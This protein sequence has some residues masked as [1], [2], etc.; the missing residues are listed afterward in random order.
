VKV[1]LLTFDGCPNA[2]AARELVARV[3]AQFAPDAEVGEIVIPDGEAAQ[4]HRFLGSPTIRVDGRDIE[5]G[6]DE[7]TDYV[8][9]CRLYRTSSGAS[10]MP[11]EAWLR[12]AL[13]AA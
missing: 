12:A 7:R 9:A 5:P 8:L 3:A 6:A 13:A 10:G 2:P 11:H 1:E 4:S